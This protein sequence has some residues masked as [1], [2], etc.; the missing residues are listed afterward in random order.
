MARTWKVVTVVERFAQEKQYDG[1]KYEI[2]MERLSCGHVRKDPV[3]FYENETAFKIKRIFEQV[4]D[5]PPKA[6]CYECAR[7][8]AKNGGH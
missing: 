6:R 2:R 5:S 4:S 3:N 7:D 1:R 8:A